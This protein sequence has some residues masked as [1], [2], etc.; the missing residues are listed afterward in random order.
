MYN[1][2]LA[3]AGALL[4]GLSDTA[5]SFEM[6]IIGR[7]VIGLNCGLNSGFCPLYIT[8]LSP[9]SIRGS[10]GTL[11]QLGVTI[12]ILL[13]QILG[14]KFALGNKQYWPLLLGMNNGQYMFGSQHGHLDT[15]PQS[16]DYVAFCLKD[17][18]DSFQ[19][20]N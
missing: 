3:I 9:K 14:L 16:Y 1:N 15:Y 5:N 10:V 8:E 4:M 13:S 20:Y 12:S 17:L 2:I 11:F 7:F 6:L 19:S 18:P